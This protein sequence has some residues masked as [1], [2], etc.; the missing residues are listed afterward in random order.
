MS[1]PVI[2]PPAAPE[3]PADAAATPGYVAPV[4]PP[5]LGRSPLPIVAISLAGLALLFAFVAAGIAWLPA[6]AAIVLAIIA[7]VKKAQ[8]RLL[9]VIALI[10]APIA[11]LIAI[12]VAVA[13]LA[14]GLGASFESSV[15]EDPAVEQ[16]QSADEDQEEADA[17]NKE[18]A[19]GETVTNSDGVAVTFQSIS[20]GLATAGPQYFEETAKGQFCEVKYNVSNGSDEEIT[21]FASDVTGEIGGI[22]YESDDVISTFGDDM[23]STSLNPGLATDAI[24]YIDIPAGSALEY[25]V[26]IPEWSFLTSEIRVRAS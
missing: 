13:S 22:E 10:V 9:A 18:A 26:Y 1:E 5:S 11:W 7:L 3:V 19:I 17:G 23:F 6:V 8:P 20:C 4:A 25:L 2:P 14:S 16:E 24:V 12:V 21:L 15:A